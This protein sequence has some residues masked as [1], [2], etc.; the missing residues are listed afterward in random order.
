MILTPG[1]NVVYACLGAR[2]YVRACAGTGKSLQGLVEHLQWSTDSQLCAADA[3]A[4]GEE[5]RAGADIVCTDG[6][7]VAPISLGQHVWCMCSLRQQQCISHVL[8]FAHHHQILLNRG[9]SGLSAVCE[10]WCSCMPA[11]CKGQQLHCLSQRVQLAQV[12]LEMPVILV[13]FTSTAQQMP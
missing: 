9:L 10:E 4:A 8:L 1:A 12:H 7:K 6:L 2:A 11:I 5:G 13:D 3:A